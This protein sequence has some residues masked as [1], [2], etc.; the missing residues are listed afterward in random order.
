MLLDVN[1]LFHPSSDLDT[2]PDHWLYA[3][4]ASNASRWPTSTPPKYGGSCLV[5]LCSAHVPLLPQTGVQTAM[6]DVWPHHDS[7]G[8][9]TFIC[10]CTGYKI[11]GPIHL[12]LPKVQ[13]FHCNN[14]YDTMNKC[15]EP[16]PS[17]NY[18]THTD[19]FSIFVLEG[20]VVWVTFISFSFSDNHPAA[21]SPLTPYTTYILPL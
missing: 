12:K 7:N 14:L 13:K 6:W 10:I 21:S 3:A 8:I 19:F 15:L 16:S 5:L 18:Y 11:W 2:R 17:T 20:D 4:H 9:S 1:L